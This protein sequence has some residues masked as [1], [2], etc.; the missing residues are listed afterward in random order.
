VEKETKNGRPPLFDK[1]GGGTALRATCEK[2]AHKG[3]QTANIL[4]H[5]QKRHDDV[6]G[7]KTAWS[8]IGKNS[9]SSSSKRKKGRGK[10]AR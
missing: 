7:A 1:A 9:P 10:K 4:L 6:K 3:G 8:R 5:E 2:A